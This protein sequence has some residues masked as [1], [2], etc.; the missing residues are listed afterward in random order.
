MTSDEV[1]MIEFPHPSQAEED[2]LLA[3]GGNLEPHTLMT[4]YAQATFPW[5]SEGQPILWWSPDPRMVF[6]PDEFH[7]SRRLARRLKQ[8]CY[9]FS[10]N[11]AFDTVINQCA[12]IPRVGEDGTWIVPEMMMAY[13]RL[14]AQGFA[15]SFEVWQGESL[16]GGL[17]GVLYKRVFFGESMFSGKRDGSKMVLAQLMATARAE[18]W[19]IIDCQFHTDHLAS[20]GGREISRQQLLDLITMPLT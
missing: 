9:R 4:A 17:Y 3:I 11:E 5:Y 1:I 7:C 12:Q 2:G 14:H 13:Q 8:S 19:L 15:H 10:H 20:L 16:V 6:F 18:G